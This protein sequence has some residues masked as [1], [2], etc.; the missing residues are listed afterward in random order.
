MSLYLRQIHIENFRRFRQPVR[1]DNLGDG[2]NVLIAPNE[3]GK[4]TLLEAVR[5]AFFV[6]TKGQSKQLKSYVP[7]GDKVGPSVAVDFALHGE[8]W[9][10]EKRFVQSAKTTLN[11]PKGRSEGEDA[12]HLLR[13]QLGAAVHGSGKKVEPEGALGLLWVRQA[14]ALELTAPDELVRDRLRMT[15]EQEVGSILGGGAFNRV[16]ERVEQLSARYGTARSRTQGLLPEVQA[17]NDL[18][19]AHYAQTKELYDALENHFSRLE[20]VRTRLK[21]VERDLRD[22]ED[23]QQRADLQNALKLAEGAAHRLQMRRVECDSARRVVLRLEALQ[24]RADDLAQEKKSDQ[25]ALAILEKERCGAEEQVAEIHGKITTLGQDL[26]TQQEALHQQRE[27]VRMA[28]Q[29]HADYARAEA[30][31]AARGRYAQLISCEAALM[32]AERLSRAVIS[33]ELMAKLDSAERE[34][35]EK[36]ALM[37]M[38]GARVT[39]SGDLASVLVNGV[40]AEAGTLTIDQPMSVT[41]GETTL[42][43]EPSLGTQRARHNLEAAQT[44]LAHV[45]KEVGVEDIETARQRNEQARHSAGR[46]QDLRERI[47]SLCPADM[48]LGL[49]AGQDALKVLMA[50]EG[51]DQRS[52]KDVKTLPDI[53][54]MRMKLEGYED[55]LLKMRTMFDVLNKQLKEMESYSQPLLLKSAQLT[56]ALERNARDLERLAQDEDWADISVKIVQAKAH[57]SSVVLEVQDAE[58]LVSVSNPDV[59]RRKI[60][61]LDQDREAAERTRA[62]LREDQSRLEATI[63]ADGGRGLAERLIAAEDEREA[64]EEAHLRIKDE[65]DTLQILRDVMDEARS[66][67][68]ERFVRPVASRAKAY[69]EKILPGSDPGFDET[70]KLSRLMR[71]QHEEESEDL[72]KGTQEQLAL[73]VRLAFA[74]I[75]QQQGQPVSLILDDPLVYADDARLDLMLDMLEQASKRLQIVILTCRERAFR[76]VSGQRLSLPCA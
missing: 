3:A 50:S 53:Q 38:D 65:V 52:V 75:L 10:V 69:V 34:V 39:L 13:E 19:K 29:C 4:S 28:E 25:A 31:D 42:T 56:A 27:S 14:E 40:E 76:S 1:L 9:R 66:E 47:I 21:H 11:G 6:R 68:G 72:S 60:E 15:L 55:N 61:R 49:S 45:L 36:R 37:G 73:M 23:Q 32:E 74:D 7:Y 64:A 17:R 54:E 33:D 58:S 16:K 18:A 5:A 51:V 35:V 59:I 62:Q 20:Q 44:R 41:I 71:G 70:L 48:V 43:L 46:I 22:E 67:M 63:S 24:K 8:Q 12:E 57:L 30:L 26:H 2:L